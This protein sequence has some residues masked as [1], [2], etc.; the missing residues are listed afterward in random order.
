MATSN[1]TSAQ[2]DAK[3]L[4]IIL[5]AVEEFKEIEQ[6]VLFG[7]RAMKSQ[8]QGSDIDIALLGKNIDR[9]VV[10]RLHDFLNNQTIIPYFIDILDFNTI[11]NPELIEHIQQN[12]LV[13][14]ERT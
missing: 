10:L 8:R 13:I 4:A 12:G 6:V 2:L 5:N 1:V 9:S 3:F 14:Y 7:S 11:S